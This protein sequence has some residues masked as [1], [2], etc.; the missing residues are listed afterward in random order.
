MDTFR[1]GSTVNTSAITRLAATPSEIA[2]GIMLR[3]REDT[4]SQMKNGHENWHEK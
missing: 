4:W 2:L 1:H 3:G